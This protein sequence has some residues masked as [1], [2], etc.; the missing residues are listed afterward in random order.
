MA[1]SKAN[2]LLVGTGGVGSI[3]ALNLE[4]GGL[5][6]V[7][8]VMRSNFAAV[9]AKGFSIKSCDHGNVEGWRPNKSKTIILIIG[10]SL[11]NLH[12]SHKS[13]PQCYRRGIATIRFYCMY[14]EKYCRQLSKFSPSDRFS[15][16]TQA[17]GYCTDSERLEH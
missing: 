9:K 7:T 6:E 16:N 10:T 14:N 2:I 12:N 8:A 5:A 15:G 11:I 3:V 4:C 1:S 17:L 13:S